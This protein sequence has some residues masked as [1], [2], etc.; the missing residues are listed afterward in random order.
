MNASHF[1]SVQDVLAMNALEMHLQISWTL[2]TNEIHDSAHFVWP[3]KCSH[4]YWLLIFLKS[5]GFCYDAHN[6]A[7]GYHVLF[8][9]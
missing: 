2:Y 5:F 9:N 6:L 1:H 4:A 3:C 8:Y 7:V